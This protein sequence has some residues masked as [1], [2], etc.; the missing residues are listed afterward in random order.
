MAST[1]APLSKAAIRMANNSLNL[2]G[3]N[4]VIVAFGELVCEEVKGRGGQGGGSGRVDA[5]VLSAGNVNFG[6][7]RLTDEGIESTFALN[8][9]SKF[10]LIQSLL[11]VLTIP[12]KTTSSSTSPDTT[13]GAIESRVV[14]ILAGGNPGKVDVNDIQIEK[15]YSFVKAAVASGVLVDMMTDTLIKQH[16]PG[17]AIPPTSPVATKTPSFYHYF[18]GVVNTNNIY[19]TGL[20]TFLTYPIKTFIMP[21]IGSAPTDI[22]EE[23]VYMLDNPGEGWRQGGVD[24]EK[25]RNGFMI[26]PGLKRMKRYEG[27]EEEEKSGGVVWRYCTGLI[28]GVLGK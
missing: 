14:S 22:A 17:T 1:S 24:L 8:Y 9:L 21:L 20:P 28:D 5:L 13:T 6:S 7:R 4:V 19:N 2:T 15:G 3:K 23:V 10:V 18:P 12:P 16:H 11:P 25:A 26:H 27:M